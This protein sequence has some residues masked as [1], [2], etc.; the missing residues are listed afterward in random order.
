MDK[1][2][3]AKLEVIARR[4]NELAGEREQLSKITR[5]EQD[6]EYQ[7]FKIKMGYTESLGDQAKALETEAVGHKDLRLTVEFGDQQ[8]EIDM[9]RSTTEKVADLSNISEKVI[10][11]LA[12]Y[13]R[14]LGNG[15]RMLHTSGNVVM[16][17]RYNEEKRKDEQARIRAEAK[18]TAE[19]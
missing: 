10:R 6:L 18:Q 12:M 1:Q 8:I 2:S 15:F 7:E 13:Q 3:K 16:Q 17:T 9:S 4:R 19:G 5:E 11:D 14:Q